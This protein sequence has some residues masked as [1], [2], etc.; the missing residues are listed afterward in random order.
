M[1]KKT[2]LLLNIIL[3]TG[4]VAYLFLTPALQGAIRYPSGRASRIEALKK[5][6][7]PTQSPFFTELLFSGEKLPYDKNTSTFYLPLN[8][9]EKAWETGELTSGQKEVSLLFEEQFSKTDKQ[10]AIR[11]GTRFPFYAF[12]DGEYQEC[13][14]VATGLPVIS[15]E[16]AAEKDAEVFGGSAFFWDSDT[17]VDWTSSSIMEG[18]I[19]GNT[20]RIYPKKGYKLSLKKQNKA[21]DIVPDKRSVFGLR[22]DDEWILNAMYTD[23]S[24]IRD[25]MS[26]DLWNAFGAKKSEYPGAKFATDFTY[27]EV[28]FN[29]EYWGLYGLLEPVDSK[30][31]DLTKEGE[32]GAP[33]YSYKAIIPQNVATKDLDTIE[34]FGKDVA[35][36]ELKGTHSSISRESWDP[37]FSYLK[38]R[39]L[40]DDDTFRK[41]A[42]SQV[43]T[44]GAL[45]VWLYLQAVLGIDNRAKNMYYV[46]KRSGD[47]YKMYFAPWDM[48]L[49][50]GDSLSEST[51]GEYPWDVGLLPNL[52]TERINWSM[53]DRLVELDVDNARERVAERWKS[54][55]ADVL[56]DEAIGE[57][58]DRMVHRTGD[59]GA[60]ARNEER[61]PESSAGA[62]YEEMKRLAIYRMRILDYYFD[63]NLEAYL[64]LGYE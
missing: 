48:D 40:A 36:F 62:D 11:E 10:T 20:S 56:S 14:L 22:K 33:E 43:D 28:F 50:W 64:G 29:Q 17:K 57:A 1:R 63:G 37:L 16:T 53:G 26:D 27:V 6:K 55:R 31:L 18:H 59:S 51:G 12:R 47:S 9:E 25:K 39:D 2:V 24:K 42:A 23:D 46:A 30:Q 21:G 41:T 19:R 45:D 54:L 15:I 60:R 61:W 44:G 52:Y 7:Q 49:T 13:F 38:L 5:E 4:F 34:E 8:M 35:G 32:P 58:V 3:L